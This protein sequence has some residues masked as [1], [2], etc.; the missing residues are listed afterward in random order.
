MF[1]Q[2]QMF[3]TI[4]PVHLRDLDSKFIPRFDAFTMRITIKIV[5]SGPRFHELNK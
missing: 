4:L 1:V 2:I 3:T 5:H